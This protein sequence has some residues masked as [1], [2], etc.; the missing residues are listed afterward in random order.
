M[1]WRIIAW[2]KFEIIRMRMTIKLILAHSHKRFMFSKRGVSPLIATVL[3]IAFAVSLG[4]VLI[5]LG[6][7][8]F[9][10][11]CPSRV[12]MAFTV[13]DQPLLCQIVTTKT[14]SITMVNP[15]KKAVDGFKLS[16]I[17]GNMSY[18]EDIPE[19][20]KPLEKKV[21]TYPLGEMEHVDLVSIIPYYVSGGRPQYCAQN[22]KDYVNIRNC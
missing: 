11:P 15:S 10:D 19:L 8:I 18:N 9:G 7:N 17:G 12:I 20:L 4:S 21:V 3:L 6:M 14:L 16:V 5:N 2:T 1:F 13:N 22:Q